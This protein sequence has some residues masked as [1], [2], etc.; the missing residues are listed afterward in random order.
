V[1]VAVRKKE[2]AWTEPYRAPYAG[3]RVKVMV[4]CAGSHGLGAVSDA[5][6]RRA[7]F[8]VE[9]VRERPV[10]GSPR[11]TPWGTQQ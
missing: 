8:S 11:G 1:S 10:L 9:I 5:L 2:A 6:A 7:P 4:T 3:R